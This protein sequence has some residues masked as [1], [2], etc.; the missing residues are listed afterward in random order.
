MIDACQK[1]ERLL[2]IGYRC[3]FEPHHRKCIELAQSKEFGEIKQMVAGF[4]FKIGDPK[5]WRLNKKLAGGGPLMDV[6]IYALQACR[7]LTGLEP[8]LITATETKT[9]PVKF[10]EVEETLSW[11]M[12][13]GDVNCSLTTTYAFNGINNFQAFCENGNFE[14]D[15]AFGYGGI[16][17]KTSKGP[18]EFEQVDHFAAELDHF[19]ECITEGTELRVPGQMGLQDLL[20]MEAIFKAAESGLAIKPESI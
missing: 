7:Y 4:G 6:G 9:D 3:Q 11:T 14:L 8:E 15:P 18:I 10:K 1:A 17:G 13:M 5:Q 2:G 19:A 16:K 12:K 20:I